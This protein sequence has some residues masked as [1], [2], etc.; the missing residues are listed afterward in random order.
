[1][2]CFRQYCFCCKQVALICDGICGVCGTFHE[3]NETVGHMSDLEKED[4]HGTN[5]FLAR[6]TS[7]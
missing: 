6:H 4:S 5:E 2:G 3:E 1:M 7:S